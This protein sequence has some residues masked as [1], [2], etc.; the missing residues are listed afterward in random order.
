MLNEENLKAFAMNNGIDA[1]GWS[2]GIEFS[3]YIEAI[4]D[5]KN[6]Y[7][8]QYRSYE[9]FIQA[10]KK[11]KEYKTVIVIIKDYFYEKVSG[12]KELKLSNYSRFCWQTINPK[13]ELVIN[14]LNINGYLG[15]NIDTPNK[16]AAC[17]AG[18]G[19]IG[20]NS[21]FYAYGL[22]SYVSIGTIGTNLELNSDQLDKKMKN[23]KCPLCNKCVKSC[24]TKAIYEDGYKINPLKCLSFINRHAN[25]LNKIIPEN[26]KE[27]KWLHGCEICQD[28]CPLNN[29][30]L[31]KLDVVFSESIDLYGMKVNNKP[32]IDDKEVSS[33]LNEISEP[34]YLKYIMALL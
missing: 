6:I 27:E 13:I 33:R 29:K 32:I 28:C 34:E 7:N 5:Q 2:K 30:I 15:H 10:G 19:F 14:Y 16:V 4:K 23:Q 31:H 1:I 3:N 9:N 26:I 8:F 17:E 21:L 18:L 25:E 11:A 12:K 22:G 20:K 24:P